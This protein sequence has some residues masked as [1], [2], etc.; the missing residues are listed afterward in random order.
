MKSKAH[1]DSARTS[2][3]QSP[4]RRGGRALASA[5]LLALA[6]Y[7]A[8][9]AW[10]MPGRAAH[11]AVATVYERRTLQPGED[12]G[13][14]IDRIASEILS[15]ANL[16][17][18][19][20]A[21]ARDE[22][23]RAAAPLAQLVERW[24]SQLRVEVSPAEGKR[25][26]TISIRSSAASASDDATA[27]VNAIAAQYCRNRQLAA[28]AEPREA[29]RQTWTELEKARQAAAAMR[30]QLD[31]EVEALAKLAEAPTAPT[32][33][34]EETG[35]QA[36]AAE[37]ERS[38]LA[39]QRQELTEAISELET[40]RLSLLERLMPAHPDVMEI[41]DEI[42][43]ARARLKRLPPEAPSPAD[44]PLRLTESPR[45]PVAPSTAAMGE[46]VAKRVAEVRKLRQSVAE[47]ESNV[48]RA[49]SKAQIAWERLAQAETAQV[50]W[51]TPA[52]PE[53]L[54]P[55]NSDWPIAA[56]IAAL[57]GI[58]LWLATSRGRRD[59]DVIHNAAELEAVLG[60]PV[61]G[62]L[63]AVHGPAELESRRD[64]GERAHRAA[65]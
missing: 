40:R 5:V 60:F 24:R 8:Y 6:V 4:N 28:S 9:R 59:D 51:M 47:A 41:D 46:E 30:R 2:P 62:S 34:E 35:D 49:A 21:S 18:A 31:A 32:T 38:N 19:I 48:D 39:R 55:S 29:F 17:E 53:P 1:S 7:A 56:A 58:A 36:A 27:R 65:G 22:A 43:Q 25:P 61:I 26:W 52:T 63:S 11:E 57:G 20:L 45:A 50:A 54:S 37:A 13:L 64:E 15:P 3:R 10:N 14:A 42:S 23:Q 16:R 12:E 44:H 33:S